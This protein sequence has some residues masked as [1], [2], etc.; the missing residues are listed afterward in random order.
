MVDPEGKNP[1]LHFMALS[2]FMANQSINLHPLK[3]AAFPRNS[4]PYF[5]LRINHMVSLN[6]AFLRA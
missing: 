3:E 6:K 4:R 2:G 5:L 1:Y